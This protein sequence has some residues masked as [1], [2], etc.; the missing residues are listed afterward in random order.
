MNWLF[1]F[2]YAGAHV[3]V[4]VFVGPDADHRALSGTITLHIDEFH[5]LRTRFPNEAF[6]EEEPAP[7]PEG[8]TGGVGGAVPSW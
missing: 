1:R 6:E 8:W 4:R 3:H 2:R 5:D 7:P